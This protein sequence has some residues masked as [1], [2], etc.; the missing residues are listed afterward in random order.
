MDEQVM[1]RNCCLSL[2]QFDIP[3]EILF[4]YERVAR[5]L[6]DVLRNHNGDSLTQ[7]IVVFLLNSMACHVEGEQK[8][9]VGN[10]GAIEV[11]VLIRCCINI[12]LIDNS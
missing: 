5:L 12:C 1:V 2:C 4:D 8:V 3:Q 11:Y 7:R 6:V 10:I 9:Q